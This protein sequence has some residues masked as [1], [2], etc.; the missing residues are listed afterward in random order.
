MES[1]RVGPY[2][3]EDQLGAG[4]MG[5]V[6]RAYDDRLDRWVAIKHIRPEALASVE[7]RRRFRR[8]A[9]A[10]ARLSHPSIVQIHDIL[11][12]EDGDSIV[13]ELVEGRPLSSLLAEG[14]LE[15]DRALEL[16]REIAEGLAEAHGKDIVHRDLKADNVMV[17]AGGHVKILD[18]GLAKSLSQAETHLSVEG[19]I[20]GTVHAMSPE[21]AQG[22]EVDHRSDLFSLGSLLY[23]MVTRQS[24]FQDSSPVQTLTRIVTFHQPSA[25]EVNPRVP[26]AL[27]RLIDQLLEKDPVHRPRSAAGVASTLADVAATLKTGPKGRQEEPSGA[28]T[29]ID[30]PPVRVDRPQPRADRG[31]ILRTLLVSDL[32]DS[33]RWV[34]QL[35]DED[36]AALFQR[37]DRRARALVAE[38]GGREID[39]TD[40]FLL[41][42]ERPIQAVL[43]AQAYHR[44]LRELSNAAEM[45]L[46]SRVGIHLGEII[47]HENAPEDVARGAKPLEVGGLAKPIAA[48]LMSLAEG[49]QTLM[50][51]A[52]FDTARRGAVGADAA[53]GELRW[54]AHGS[55]RLKGIEEPVEIF[56][57]GLEGMAPLHRPRD[58]DK[59]R[60]VAGEAVPPTLR[61]RVAA[62]L[63][64]LSLALLGTWAWWR[65]SEQRLYVAVL[66]PEV[67]SAVNTEDWDLVAAAVRLALIQALLSRQ[68]ISTPDPDEVDTV[69]GSAAQVARALG[70]DEVVTSN[71]SCGDRRCQIELKRIHGVDGSVGWTEVFSVYHGNL[72]ELTSVVAQR[73]HSGYPEH[74]ARENTREMHVAAGDYEQYLR[75]RRALETRSEGIS[76]AEL[77]EAVAAIES[78]S[79]RFLEAYLLEARIAQILFVSSRRPADLERALDAVQ[80]ARDLAPWDSRALFGL[81]NVALDGARPELAEEA[82]LSLQ[83]IEPGHGR[84]MAQQALLLEVRGKAEEA[85]THMRTAV[86]RHPSWSNLIDLA[87]MENRF[88]ELDAAR[89]HLRELLARSPDNYQ[90]LFYLA[91]H[92][93]TYGSLERAIELFE[94]LRLQAPSDLGTRLN[95][96]L[97]YIGL[98]RY[99]EAA[100]WFHGIL[101]IEPSHLRAMAALAITRFLQGE[102]EPARVLA[103]KILELSPEDAGVAATAER[104]FRR[105]MALVVLGQD[106]QAVAAVQQILP[107]A[108]VSPFRAW[109]A[110]L[111]YAAVDERLSAQTK[112][113]EAMHQGLTPRWFVAPVFD[114]LKDDPELS[115]LLVG[116]DERARQASP[117]RGTRD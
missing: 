44:A 101:E 4:G 109:Q 83:R 10:A 69:S 73:L 30:P 65:Q 38:H 102:Q 49:G 51:R 94:Q 41:L 108:S 34:E 5:E 68:G 95:I 19:K 97:N 26:E 13:M 23:Q 60:R 46:S 99:D 48:R 105:A 55:Y 40:G 33:T 93:M 43:Y 61:R 76:L 87:R 15:I 70:V 112:A 59:A 36:A 88:G 14:P 16:A 57:V 8:E 117:Q 18:F 106:E 12:S 66:R 84:I 62:A 104:H 107:A 22:F 103:T 1:R 82:L 11:E 53:A 72:L 24:P 77:L 71:L 114:F 31:A 3:I 32:V 58:G 64:L 113:R 110:A 50:T 90:V 96:G 92:E 56:E 89:D 85:L 67:R 17:T 29:L 100:R 9:R 80:R 39:K 81:F 111:I 27:S 79:P 47:L 28:S 37:H 20:L 91:N 52:A 86:E 42:F 21:Q 6:F 45:E 74:K 98:A 115:Q 116:Y 63:L 7:A 54:L 2:R 75:L 25:R 35:G 78:T